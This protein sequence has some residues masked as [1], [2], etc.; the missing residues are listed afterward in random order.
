TVWP[1]ASLMSWAMENTPNTLRTVAVVILA[2]ALGAGALGM[3][4][5]RA[6]LEPIESRFLFNP[7]AVDK[8]R[9]H[10]LGAGRQGVEEVRI[11]T[12]DG[13]SL[14]GWLKRPASATPGKRYP[15]VIVY[16]GVR[17]E[18][19]EFVRA[20]APGDWGWL[21]V[22]YRGF[23]LSEGEPSETHVLE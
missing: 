4:G 16:G 21:V 18:V 17:R 11:V 10:S 8:D 6:L 14:H 15:L 9:L 2:A 13:V 3:A 7:R 19:S 23:G 22:N 20:D 1:C 12:P 5:N